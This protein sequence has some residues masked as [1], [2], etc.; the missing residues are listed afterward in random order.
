MEI[1]VEV[2]TNYGT[3]HIYPVCKQ[4]KLFAELT[5]KKTLTYQAIDTIRRMGY[6]INVVPATI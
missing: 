4:G 5:G 1:L 3:Q 6:K 2:K